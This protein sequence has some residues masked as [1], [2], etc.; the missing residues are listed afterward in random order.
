MNRDV[1]EIRKSLEKRKS[2]RIKAINQST[3]DHSRKPPNSNP[4]N[5]KKHEKEKETPIFMK[6]LI[7]AGIVFLLAVLIFQSPS[8][9]NELK[10]WASGQVN[11]EFPFATV[12]V[13]YQEQFGTPFGFF[14]DQSV[15][16]VI[17][18]ESLPVLGMVNESIDLKG[19]G[20]II[21]VHER[22]VFTVEQG[23]VLFV[24]TTKE[25]GKTVVVQH[26]DRSKSTYGF[27]A[28]ANVR[29]YQFVEASQHIGISSEPIDGEAQIYFSLK[30][31]NQFI[32]PQEVMRVNGLE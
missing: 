4:A 15:T 12:N 18:Q 7:G 8:T 6:Q 22:D 2:E 25:T 10:N 16:P 20:V 30:K 28:E 3:K 29:P 27:L 13:W 1:N 11:E 19:Q 5:V 17:N 31:G 21:N 23:T 24:G 26:P 14:V 9:P 32:D